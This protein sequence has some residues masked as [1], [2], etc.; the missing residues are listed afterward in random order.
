MLTLRVPQAASQSAK[1]LK[2]ESQ[3]SRLK[4]GKVRLIFTYFL[5]SY[6]CLPRQKRWWRG[7]GQQ[8][9]EFRF[10]EFWW[11]WCRSSPTWWQQ[12]AACASADC[13]EALPKAV[14]RIQKSTCLE[15]TW[16]CEELGEVGKQHP[17]DA[18]CSTGSLLVWALCR[19][20]ILRGV[21][22]LCSSQACTVGWLNYWPL[23]KRKRRFHWTKSGNAWGI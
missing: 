15:G 18:S 13:S 1:P 8:Q 7:T 3:D 10:W 17:D 6:Y 14:E 5:L 16:I 21:Y 11:W 22:C 9:R 4:T 23:Q 2:F 12:S 20:T 19:H